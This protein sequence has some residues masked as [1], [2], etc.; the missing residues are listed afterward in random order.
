MVGNNNNFKRY[1][2]NIII[3]NILKVSQNKII[4]FE[5]I[6]KIKMDSIESKS[7][8]TILLNELNTKLTTN[9]IEPNNN[10]FY[11]YGWIC[12]L[13]QKKESRQKNN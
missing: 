2:Y 4:K 10:L 7:S 11:I 1:C 5:K 8:L 9:L 6:K 12:R 13:C 3:N